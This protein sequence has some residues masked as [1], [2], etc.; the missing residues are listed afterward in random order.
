M[1]FRSDETLTWAAREMTA[2]GGGWYASLDADSEGE[3]GRFYVWTPDEIRSIAGADAEACVAAWGVTA[4]GN[5]EGHN[6]LFVADAAAA[7][8]PSVARAREAL[9]AARSQRVWPGRDEKLVASWNGLM[10][11]AMAE[12]GRIFDDR[13]WIEAAC[14]AAEFLDRELVRDNRARRT[15]TA[16][17]LAPVGFLE[18]GRAHV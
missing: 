15:W 1:L 6:I 4:T 11:R 18:I 16:G 17:D 10:L 12:A 9:Y 7:G 8:S 14:S 2:P 3:E 13:R 5:F